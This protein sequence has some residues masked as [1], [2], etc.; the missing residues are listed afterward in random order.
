MPLHLFIDAGVPAAL[1]CC[2]SQDHSLQIRNDIE[3]AIVV[4]VMLDP[5]GLHPHNLTPTD[6]QR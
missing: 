1:L 3:L 6:Q 4:V 2:A 5:W